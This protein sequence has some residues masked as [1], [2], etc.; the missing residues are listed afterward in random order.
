MKHSGTITR[1]QR[2]SDGVTLILDT[3]FGLRG[4]EVDLDVWAAILADTGAEKDAELIGW[5]VRYD[6]ATGDIE[7]AEPDSDEPD[8]DEAD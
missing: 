2:A 8:G 4:V 7:M 3:D 1:V 5:A 6:P